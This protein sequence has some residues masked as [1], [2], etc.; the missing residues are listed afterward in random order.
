[1][2]SHDWK[3]VNNT[4]QAK[5]LYCFV[6]W[7]ITTM[8]FQMLRSQGNATRLFKMKSEKILFCTVKDDEEHFK[9]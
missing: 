5:E 3:W 4:V 7:K 2:L 1:M 8:K 9:I 6:I